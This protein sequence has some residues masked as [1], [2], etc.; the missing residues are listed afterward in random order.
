MAQP[1]KSVVESAEAILAAARE[2]E[3]NPSDHGRR[4]DLLVQVEALRATL[5]DP[6]EA[7]F[8]QFT[9]VSI[10]IHPQ[11]LVGIA[12]MHVGPILL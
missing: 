7:M 10:H 2:Q 9:N 4:R 12:I 6:R 11:P 5:E 3:R 1:G 8:R